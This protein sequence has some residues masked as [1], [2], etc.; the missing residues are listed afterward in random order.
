MSDMR[1]GDESTVRKREREG[2]KTRTKREKRCKGI[3]NPFSN[4]KH[5]KARRSEN[6]IITVSLHY[7]QNNCAST[8]SEKQ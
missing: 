6:K 7:K 5:K 4:A 2:E 3:S 8:A 1:G